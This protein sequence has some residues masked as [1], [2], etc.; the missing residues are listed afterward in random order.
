MN[1]YGVTACVTAAA[2]LAVGMPVT[3]EAANNSEMR[4]KVIRLS[5]IMS[6]S[7]ETAMVTRAEYAQMLV[8][9]STYKSVALQTSS[10]AVF[11][12]VPADSTYASAVRI[13]VE[14]GWMSGYLGGVFRPEQ[15]VT[16]QEAIRGILALL[17]YTDEDFSGNQ[18]NG[19]WAKFNYLELNENITKEPLEVLTRMDCVNLFY[20]LLCA[21]T[22]SGR[23]YCTLL[24]YELSSDGEVNPLTIA[25]NELK[26]PKVVKK[27][28]SLSDY[29]PFDVNDA[30]FY[31]DGIMSTLERVRQEKSNGFLVI[32][33]NTNTKTIWAYSSARSGEAIGGNMMAIKGEISGIFYSSSNVMTPST[34]ILDGDEDT[35]YHL[36]DADVQFAFSI[37]GEFRV[38]DQVVLICETAGTNSNGD[39]S[40]KVIDYIEY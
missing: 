40:Y 21:E 10:T 23:A 5:G 35:Q 25:D 14:N 11:S 28:Y 33:Y 24:G 39:P 38:G 7:D 31:L 3:A 15:Q 19:R 9:A 8:N 22:S 20:N 17:G 36:E 6:L 12:D 30:T 1:P 26:G 4:R 34:L 29:V 18:I 2:V 27:D 16:L 13:A 32:Y 37:Y